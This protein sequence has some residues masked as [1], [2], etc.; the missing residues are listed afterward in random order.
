MPKK[1]SLFIGSSTEGLEVA[2]A[3]RTQLNNDAEVTIWN[4]GIFQL[5]EGYLEALVNAL[6]MFDFSV[7]VFSADDAIESRGVTHIAPR[8]NIMFELGLFMGRLGRARTFVLYDSA[9]HP[10]LPSD[11]A[12][13]SVAQYRSDRADGNFIAAVGTA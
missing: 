11:L 7:L 9:K 3:L 8:D 1:P 10:K 5:T 4:E 12:G 6:P 2:R 13:V